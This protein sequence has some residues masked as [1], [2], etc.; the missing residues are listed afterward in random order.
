MSKKYIE[1]KTEQG[2]KGGKGKR[3]IDFKKEWGKNIAQKQT[4]TKRKMKRGR[5]TPQDEEYF[6][7][8]RL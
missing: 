5:K 7:S 3:E 6:H 1:K 4:E 2:L 8:F